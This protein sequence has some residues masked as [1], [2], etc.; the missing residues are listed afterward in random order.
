[1]IFCTECY[2]LFII[3][4]KVCY[5]CL[6]PAVY[7]GVD[8]SGPVPW[9]GGAL[10]AFWV[11]PKRSIPKPDQH[12]KRYYTEGRLFS[13][14]CLSDCPRS[15]RKTAWAINIKLVTHILYSSRS[16]G[17]DPEVR[18]SRSHGYVN[19]HGRTVASDACCHS[20]CWRGCACRFGCLC[21]LVYF[22]FIN[23]V[24]CCFGFSIDGFLLSFASCIFVLCVCVCVCV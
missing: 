4:I 6:V 17:I 23:C 8:G 2:L 3:N 14:F 7:M 1:M 22:V 20:L 11:L 15:N 24:L 18:R 21:F 10:V 9:M 13:R 5:N 19:R 12:W 16:A